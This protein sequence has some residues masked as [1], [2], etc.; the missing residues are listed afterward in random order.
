MLRPS[1]KRRAALI[2]AAAGACGLLAGGAPAQTTVYI[3]GSG[4]PEVEVNLEVLEV[5]EPAP[6]PTRRLLPVGPGKG[7]G[8]VIK[9][10]PPTRAAAGTTSVAP[11]PPPRPDRVPR[12]VGQPAPRA[13]PAPK[14][15]LPLPAARP[16]PKVVAELA[17]TPKVPPPA[18]QP[19][20]KAATPKITAEPL[21][22]TPALP[23]SKVPSS[24]AVVTLA[25]RPLV[26]AAAPKPARAPSASSPLASE[27]PAASTPPLA[28]ST[29]KAPEPK[30]AALPPAKPAAK[31]TSRTV[32]RID[33]SGD[34]VGL[35]DEAKPDLLAL[36][37]R[38]DKNES[39]RVQVK[40]FA[41]GSSGTPGTARRL[42]LSRALS[43]RAF[44][45]D[46]G[47]RST[48]IDVRALGNKS[49]SGPSERVDVVL[50]TR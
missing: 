44:L 26:P 9:L 3:G 14:P 46:R 29:Q 38:L 22:A 48:R 33:F 1:I 36:A 4:L 12:A 8:P 23:P 6:A 7:G 5:F 31:P 28:A 24:A 41:S 50:L 43:I 27:K 20:P 16:L 49:G 37:E 25:P 2:A 47:V 18:P 35:P 11:P 45:I 34:L 39:L 17:P 42:S 10:R 15:K 19:L 13:A 21:P 40:A 30:V 32:L